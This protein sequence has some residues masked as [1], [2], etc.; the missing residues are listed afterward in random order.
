MDDTEDLQDEVPGTLVANDGVEGRQ[1]LSAQQDS[2]LALEGV[3]SALQ[4]ECPNL[5]AARQHTAIGV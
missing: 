4:G 5:R 1:S 3:E 2:R